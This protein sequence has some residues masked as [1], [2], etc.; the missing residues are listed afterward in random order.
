LICLDSACF[1]R[2]FKPIEIKIKKK[3]N[4]TESIKA[5]KEDPR[6]DPAS[7]L[8]IP[9]WVALPDHSFVTDYNYTAPCTSV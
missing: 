2:S 7:G 3:V 1:S 5:F 6:V 8:S 4:K 9:K